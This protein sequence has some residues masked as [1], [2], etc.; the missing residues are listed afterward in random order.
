MPKLKVKKG[1]VKHVSKSLVTPAGSIPLRVYSGGS[2]YGI[3]LTTSTATSWSDASN[4]KPSE[5]EFRTPI[6]IQKGSGYYIK[7]EVTYTDAGHGDIAHS[8]VAH[9]DSH[10]DWSNH[11]NWSNVPSWSNSGTSW[12]NGDWYGYHYDYFESRRTE[13]LYDYYYHYDGIA[14]YDI[15]KSSYSWSAGSHADYWDYG[16]GTLK[17]GSAHGD[18]TD[19]SDASSHSDTHSN[20]AHSDVLH[21]DSAHSNWYNIY[22]EPI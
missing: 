1:N 6:K 14:K 16:S 11:S 22:T 3:P 19:H 9:S 18:Y 7:S 15:A 20:V 13:N 12:H 21:S 4:T 17:S 2:S 10:S 5:P 8:D